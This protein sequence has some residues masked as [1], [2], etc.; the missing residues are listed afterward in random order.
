[1]RFKV[2]FPLHSQQ[3]VAHK[4]A[5]QAQYAG[6]IECGTLGQKSVAGLSVAKNAAPVVLN[7]C[8]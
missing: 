6:R 2:L 5:I 7:V 1:M 4:A 3:G 8:G